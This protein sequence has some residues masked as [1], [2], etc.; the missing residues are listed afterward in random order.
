MK[1]II[2][3]IISYRFSLFKVFVYEILYI[4]QG[5]KG[6][7]FNIR[8][9][10]KTTDTIPCPY[11]FLNKIL[12]AIKDYNIQSITDIGCG[13]GRVLSFFN[14]KMQLNLIG[15]ELFND[16]YEECKNAFKNNKNI[17]I[18]KGDF[19]QSNIGEGRT[20][21]YFI[22]DP[23][24]ELEL[25]NLL[26]SGFLNNLNKCRKP[27]YIVAVNMTEDKLGVFSHLEFIKSDLI[28][29]KGFKLYKLN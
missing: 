3:L 2:E 11:F 5:Y 13:N 4:L 14:K 12:L 9:N 16:S 25:H 29:I 18:L 28:G 6:N 15:Y 20:D 8:N 19:F 7:N 21:C 10:L 27:I 24:K 17:T 26:F 23:I 1:K 22:N